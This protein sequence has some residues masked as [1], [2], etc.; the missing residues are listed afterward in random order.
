MIKSGLVRI[1]RYLSVPNGGNGDITPNHPLAK[2]LAILLSVSG[3]L[4]I[5]FIVGIIIGK[6]L[7]NDSLQSS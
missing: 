6:Y 1:C 5:T 2:S 7:T 3:Q 4:Y